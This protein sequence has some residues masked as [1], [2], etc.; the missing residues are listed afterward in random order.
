[1]EDYTDVAV[2]LMTPVAC[3]YSLDHQHSLCTY[4]TNLFVAIY[5]TFAQNHFIC[6]FF[7]ESQ[8]R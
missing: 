3:F 6:L 4:S 1:M 7:S 5:L 8:Q 2:M